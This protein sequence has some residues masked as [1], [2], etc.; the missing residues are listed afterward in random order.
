[1]ILAIVTT[2]DM[3]RMESLSRLPSI[4][5]RLLR[6]LDHGGD[7]ELML[8]T[9]VATTVQFG[10]TAYVQVR[11]CASRQV[12][13]ENGR[14]R[15]L[16]HIDKPLHGVNRRGACPSSG[17]RVAGAYLEPEPEEEPDP[18][19]P[20]DAPE[21]PDEPEPIAPDP[22]ELELPGEPLAPELWSPARR[23]QPTAVRLSA[24]TTNKSLDVVLSAFILV[25]FTKS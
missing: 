4:R 12:A 6:R 7:N 8:V 23:S 17:E 22:D 20:P 9:R 10:R 14:G 25:P 19:L 21:E 11:Q 3:Q 5:R 18:E 24:A 16:V 2:Q 15:R 1:M 13:P